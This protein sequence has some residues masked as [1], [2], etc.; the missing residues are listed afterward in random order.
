[1]KRILLTRYR[2][3]LEDLPEPAAR[4]QEPTRPTN[5]FQAFASYLV[6]ANANH[7]DSQELGPAPKVTV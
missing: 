7:L 3:A 6:R 1:M 2:E 5:S 4:S